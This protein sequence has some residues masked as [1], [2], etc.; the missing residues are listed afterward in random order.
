VHAQGFGDGAVWATAE[1]HLAT[2]TGNVWVSVLNPGQHLLGL[3]YYVEVYAKGRSESRY[4][5]IKS[6]P[7]TG[8]VNTWRYTNTND[9]VPNSGRFTN[10]QTTVF[11]ASFTG[12][13][14]GTYDIW[15]KWWFKKPSVST[16]TGPYGFNVADDPHS[17]IF[18]FSS[19][20][21]TSYD[22]TS[23]CNL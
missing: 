11:F 22:E 14:D 2:N 6:G 10:Y 9:F 13:R 12:S 5:L 20:Y 15:V 18:T 7:A 16:W 23:D 21:G 3:N 1:C 4:N 19:S 17:H 8:I